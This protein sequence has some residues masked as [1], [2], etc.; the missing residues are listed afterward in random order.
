[1]AE[2]EAQAPL[3]DIGSVAEVSTEQAPVA[4]TRNVAARRKVPDRGGFIWG[5]GRRKSSVARVRIKPGD[6]KLLINKKEVSD[7]F[8]Q[9]KDRND[10]V[11]PLKIVDCMKA[12]DIYVNVKGGGTTGQS[13]AVRLGI[14]R[15][16][17]NYDE[18][19]LLKLR[20]SG[21]LTRDGRMVERKKPGQPGARKS[22]QFSKR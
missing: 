8:T 14:A 19:M 22:F 4:I 17:V 16:L 10:V 11:A 18:T 20:D 9:V 2:N 7:Y 1:M 5:L 12:F 15:A 13:G 3:I 21:Y 6:G